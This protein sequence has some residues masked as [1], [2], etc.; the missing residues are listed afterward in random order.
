MR[1]TWPG[2][3]ACDRGGAWQRAH[4]LLRWPGLK[5]AHDGD[6]EEVTCVKD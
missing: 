1:A 3:A 6:D 4:L 2:M 5:A